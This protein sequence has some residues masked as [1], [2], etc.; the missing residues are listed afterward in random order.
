MLLAQNTQNIT[1][2]R[3][4]SLFLFPNKEN[5]EPPSYN[6]LRCKG[7]LGASGPGRS[8]QVSVEWNSQST[9]W[10]ARTF[11]NNGFCSVD[12]DTRPSV[13]DGG[14]RNAI[15]RQ[16]LSSPLTPTADEWH[17]GYRLNLVFANNHSSSIVCLAWSTRLLR[18]FLTRSGCRHAGDS[19]LELSNE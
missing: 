17:P 9:E 5:L 3:C 19:S 1:C 11:Q 4:F 10:R 7:I 6:K 18:Q 15:N 8:G 2:F 14:Y 16:S 13:Q 12:R